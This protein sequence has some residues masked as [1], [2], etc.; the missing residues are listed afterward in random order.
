VPAGSTVARE[1]HYTSGHVRGIKNRT[2]LRVKI[3]K[4]DTMGLFGKKKGF[5]ELLDRYRTDAAFRE[6]LQTDFDRAISDYNLSPEEK[7]TARANIGT[8]RE[9][10]AEKVLHDILDKYRNDVL[11]RR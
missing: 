8:R 10:Y 1:V 9:N 3:A 2:Q 6:Q 4:G 7:A 11:P 5:D